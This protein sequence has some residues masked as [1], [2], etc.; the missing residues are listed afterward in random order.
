MT[1]AGGGVEGFGGVGQTE[2][3]TAAERPEGSILRSLRQGWMMGFG[4]LVVGLSSYALLRGKWTAPFGMLGYC[5]LALSLSSQFNV[6]LEEYL[7]ILLLYVPF[8]L[9]YPPPT[10]YTHSEHLPQEPC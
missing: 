3:R 5:V 2:S 8:P 6:I 4:R 7:C 1:C 10:C 9:Q